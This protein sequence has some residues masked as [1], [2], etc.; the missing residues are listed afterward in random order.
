M[1]VSRYSERIRSPP[2]ST[3]RGCGLGILRVVRS[4]G[5][6][7]KSDDDDIILVQKTSAETRERLKTKKTYCSLHKRKTSLVYCTVSESSH[8]TGLPVGEG[9]KQKTKKKKLSYFSRSRL[10]DD[11]VVTDETK[12]IMNGSCDRGGRVELLATAAAADHLQQQQRTAAAA[13][14]ATETTT[15][16]V[17]A[18]T[19]VPVVAQQTA[20]VV[21]AVAVGPSR[22]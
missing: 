6:S 8:L 1:F 21:P 13:S 2:R 14:K 4:A 16:T 3:C 20:S 18:A 12:N 22:R 19:A 7:R 17:A 11:D 10:N 5:K 9:K 15:P